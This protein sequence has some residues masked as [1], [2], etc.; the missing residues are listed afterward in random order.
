MKRSYML[1][2]ITIVLCNCSKTDKIQIFRGD[3]AR[4]G[5]YESKEL[6][7]APQVKWKVRIQNESSNLLASPVLYQDKVYFG[8]L[9]QTLYSI[10][11]ETG[12][13]NWMFEANGDIFNSP[14][15]YN[16]IVY[17]C[18]WYDYQSG[19][20]DFLYAVDIKNGSEIWKF[21]TN[22]G[23][24]SSPVIFENICYFGCDD[25]YLYAVDINDG[26]LKWKYEAYSNI[27][28]SA[29]ISK[30]FICFGDM[31]GIIYCLDLNTG[32]ELWQYRTDNQIVTTPAIFNDRVYCGSW[33]NCLYAFEL[34]NGELSWLYRTNSDITSSPSIDKK[35]VYFG[36][37]EG[38]FFSIKSKS[39][40]LSWSIETNKPIIYSSIIVNNMI[41]FSNYDFL[42]CVNKN[43]G[44]V[45]WKYELD[46]SIGSLYYH[47]ENIYYQAS[48]NYLYCLA[49]GLSNKVQVDEISNDKDEEDLS[50][51]NRE[52]LIED[53]KG[54]VQS[55]IAYY[56]TPKTHGGGGHSWPT[57]IDIVG[58]WIGHKY[59]PIKKEF[60]TI[61]GIFSIKCNETTIQIIGTGNEIGYDNKNLVKVQ[62]DAI[63]E[64]RKTEIWL[65]N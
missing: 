17:F 22:G 53:L 39:G 16:D 31:D 46:Y 43:N 27:I 40:E 60:K 2:L 25:D 51:Q 14:T 33:D 23:I 5:K 58:E 59:N 44:S 45:I 32:K 54:M 28:S 15:I 4:T 18:S 19:W 7:E 49:S 63:G 55:A 42:Y 36:D 65:L 37:N 62:I 8:D 9:S 47:N 11:S 61:N 6:K 24:N 13:I 30:D 41:Y 57:S 50:E 21:K 64:T 12:K 35:R 1:L 52:A 29:A 10:D 26:T 38:N 20:D 56:K 3:I 48:N 34:K